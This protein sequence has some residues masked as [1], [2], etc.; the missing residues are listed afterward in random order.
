MQ[1]VHICN[2]SVRMIASTHTQVLLILLS[3]IIQC[4]DDKILCYI[5]VTSR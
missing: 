1:W 2:T 5:E 4:W 3:D